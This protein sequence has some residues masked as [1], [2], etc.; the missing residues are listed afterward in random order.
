[1]LIPCLGLSPSNL[2]QDFLPQQ[3]QTPVAAVLA[4]EAKKRKSDDPS[5]SNKS[6]KPRPAKSAPRNTAVFI[7]HLPA[8]TTPSLLASV[9]SKAGLILE[10]A[11]GD[12]RIKLYKDEHGN[13]K[14]EALVVYLK[15]ESVELAVRL[16]DETELVLGSGQG[17]M[18]VKKAE[19]EKKDPLDGEGKK[20]EGGKSKGNGK[21][22]L[23]KQQA[24]RRA[25]KLKEYVTFLFDALRQS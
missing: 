19:W 5:N 4:R 15:E 23:E 6:K 8:S 3:R 17:D 11:N 9:F 21:S 16:L 13:F 22:E 25:G 18:R 20:E 1:M 14:G 10:D 7:S 24:G 2:T 12:A